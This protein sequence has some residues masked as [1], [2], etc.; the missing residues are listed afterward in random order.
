M[1]L[2]YGTILLKL[3]F[4]AE[5]SETTCTMTGFRNEPS[6][7]WIIH[8]SPIGPLPYKYFG[9]VGFSA[10]TESFTAK[11]VLAVPYN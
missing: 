1:S 2:W 11:F 3:A 8:S 6:R 7:L 10:I 4:P 5:L 9:T